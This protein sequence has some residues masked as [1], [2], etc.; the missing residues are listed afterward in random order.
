VGNKCCVCD[1]P[2]LCARMISCGFNPSDWFVPSNAQLSNPGYACRTQWDPIV[3]NYW[4]STE[5][6]AASACGVAFANG[7][8]SAF[9]KVSG[10]F[11]RAFRCVTY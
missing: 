5:S 4:S 7:N 8:L 2:T 11:V 6:V 3:V 10:N 9:N 1:W